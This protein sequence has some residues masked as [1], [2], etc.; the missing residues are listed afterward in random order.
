[1]DAALLGTTAYDWVKDDKYAKVFVIVT[2]S[3]VTGKLPQL[4]KVA[5]DLLRKG[6]FRLVVVVNG[7][8]QK[9]SWENYVVKMNMNAI[10]TD[11]SLVPEQFNT[12][13][14]IPIY[15][16]LCDEKLVS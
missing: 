13:T 10:V 11:L 14:R 2:A 12:E 16:V 15:R 6:N 8:E 9:E 5:G 3:T 7:K 4:P 1:M